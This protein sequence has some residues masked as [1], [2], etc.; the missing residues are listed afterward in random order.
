MVTDVQSIVNKM[1]N[2]PFTCSLVC[3]AISMELKTYS[4]PLVRWCDDPAILQSADDAVYI[5]EEW[6]S[7]Q[8]KNIETVQQITEN[9]YVIHFVGSQ[10]YMEV[11][12]E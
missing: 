1:L 2:Q 7:L 8:T 9:G 3:P 6:L 12:F 10:D 4:H 11:V 5:D